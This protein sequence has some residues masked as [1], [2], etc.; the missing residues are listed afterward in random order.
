[1]YDTEGQRFIIHS[2]VFA[3]LEDF[4]IGVGF[5]TYEGSCT[6]FELTPQYLSKRGEKNSVATLSSDKQHLQ[7][8]P[9]KELFGLSDSY[10][11][12]YVGIRTV[13]DIP[14]DVFVE[15]RVDYPL[16]GNVT[17]AELSFARKSLNYSSSDIKHPEHQ[18]PVKSEMYSE[19]LVGKLLNPPSFS[20]FHR[21]YSV[22]EFDISLHYV[23][24]V[25]IRPCFSSSSMVWFQLNVTYDID[26]KQNMKVFRK[27]CS[28]AV[29]E[30][31][32]VDVS[33]VT[34]IMVSL[35]QVN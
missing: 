23:P 8:K 19:S 6:T 10:N 29:A 33:R 5:V 16:P 25:D 32:K 35:G 12:T 34:G 30:K 26:L 2:S 22:Y 15:K 9:V 11:V 18:V 28:H 4:R 24:F 17:I 14:C 3:L 20:D 7:L 31:A 1:M 27:S 13:N 21:I